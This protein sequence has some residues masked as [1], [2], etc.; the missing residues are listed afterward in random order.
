MS[1][2]AFINGRDDLTRAAHLAI[3]RAKSRGSN[4]VSTDDL[5][6]GLLQSIARFGIVLIGPL[7]I[8]LE[9]MG[10]DPLAEAEAVGK[11]VVYSAAAATLFDRAAAV[12]K[13][14]RSSKL[15][16]VHMLAAFSGEES[17]LMGRLKSMHGFDSA[18]WRTAL[19][20]WQQETSARRDKGDARQ[21]GSVK[22]LLSPDDAAEFLGVHTQTVRGYIRSG[23]LAAHRL[24]GERAVRIRRQDLLDLLEPYEPD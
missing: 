4:E 22:E 13:R 6:A 14:D 18:G 19:A 16:P 12:A 9:V 3:A 11:K 21:T 7:A 1:D 2:D 17:G 20:R 10:E 23:K 8:D 15:G 5:L 24:A